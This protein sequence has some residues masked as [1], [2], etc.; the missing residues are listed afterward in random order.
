M[1]NFDN[2]TMMRRRDGGTSTSASC[3]FQG[4][5]D[6]YGLGVR[7]G[8]YIQWLSTIL[9]YNLLKSEISSMSSVNMCYELALLTSLIW[10]TISNG[11]DLQAIEPFLGLLFCFGGV[12]V[13][14]ARALEHDKD[15]QIGNLFNQ[16][17]TVAVCGYG[18]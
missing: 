14:S 8:A 7:L 2:A 10:F 6:M 15:G 1:E 9:A 12:C 4:N 16:A 17:L 11:S 3:G 13:S 5:N 18:V